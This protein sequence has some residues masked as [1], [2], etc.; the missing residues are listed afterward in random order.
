MSVCCE[1]FATHR[2]T[3]GSSSKPGVPLQDQETWQVLV[4]GTLS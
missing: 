4:C 1:N 3:M 2:E